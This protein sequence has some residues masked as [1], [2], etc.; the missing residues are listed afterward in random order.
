MSPKL[1]RDGN[2]IAKPRPKITEQPPH[3]TAPVQDK[4]SAPARQQPDQGVPVLYDFVIRCTT[5]SP[6]GFDMA[7]VCANCPY[8]ATVCSDAMLLPNDA[9]KADITHV[10]MMDEG[11]DDGSA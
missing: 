11:S 3:P 5:L 7:I 10:L 6:A 2:I 9:Q 4:Q 8:R 1:D